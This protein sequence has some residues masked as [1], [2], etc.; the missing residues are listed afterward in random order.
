[1]LQRLL[2]VHRVGL[3][4]LQ[5]GGGNDWEHRPK[6]MLFVEL[7]EATNVPKMDMIGRCDPFV[8]FAP[9]LLPAV[10]PRMATTGSKRF[11]AWSLSTL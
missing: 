4:V 10:H 7:L 1:M 2:P 6:G 8:R 9:G 5:G 3:A 11:A